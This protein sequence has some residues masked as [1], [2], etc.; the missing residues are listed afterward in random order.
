M[1]KFTEKRFVLGEDLLQLDKLLS[2]H[3]NLFAF[4]QSFY[5]FLQIWASLGN[6]FGLIC[7]YPNQFGNLKWNVIIYTY[8]D[9]D[10]VRMPIL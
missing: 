8:C 6:S 4:G 1:L 2:L 7:I 9:I 3:K 5:N 10:Q